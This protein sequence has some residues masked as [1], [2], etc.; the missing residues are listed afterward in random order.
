LI[1]KGFY[2]KYVVSQSQM[3][4]TVDSQIAVP[5]FVYYYF[6]SV[7][8]RTGLQA[9]SITSGVPHINLGILKNLNVPLPKISV[10]Q[11]IVSILSAYDDLIEN[12][13]K[14]IKLLEEKARLFF[15][16]FVEEFTYRGNTYQL[17]IKDCLSFYVGGG[18]GDE[19]YKEGYTEPAYVIRGTDILA[20]KGGDLANLPLRFHKPSNLASRTL[21]AGD[22]VFEISNGQINN[23]GRSLLVSEKILSQLSKPVICASFAKLI[24]VNDKVSPEFFHLYLNDSQENGLLYKYKSNSANGI[25]NFAFEIF[26][27]EVS[28]HLPPEKELIKF[29]DQVRP[30]F[31]L[32]SSLGEQ[33][34]KLR[35]AR[36]ILLPRLMSGEI[37]V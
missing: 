5:A 27:N 1:P 17:L 21:A 19:E 32:I 34:T 26:I 37:D 20:V 14:R 15:K 11:K 6:S 2:D 36:D 7:E 31:S 8:G 29:T 4:L 24:R 12:N 10:Q 3:K 16:T 30:I 33:N 28:I 18:W 13:L 9:H 23:I 22:I 35:E 25:N